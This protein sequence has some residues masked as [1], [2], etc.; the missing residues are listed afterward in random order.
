MEYDDSQLFNFV[1]GLLLGA[2]IGA[3]IAI[4]TAPQKGVKV[5]KRLRRAAG[6]FR[7]VATDRWDE[8]A[9]DVKGKVDE[10]FQ[11]ARSRLR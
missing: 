4:L 3:G 7:E 10:V 9:D 5:R 6:D 1:T 11:G 8:I 2:A